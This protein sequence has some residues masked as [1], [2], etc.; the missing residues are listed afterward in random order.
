MSYILIIGAKSD[1]AKALV[2]KYAENGY[3]LYLA[4]RQVIELESFAYDLGIRTRRNIKCLELDLLDF[5]SH[6]TFYNSIKEKPLGVILAVGYLGEQKKARRDFGEARKIID[7]NFTGAVSMLNIITD[8]F[9]ERKNGF[10]VGI[11]SVAGDRG[12]RKNYIYGSAKSAFTSYLSGLRSNLIGANV[13]ILT[14]IPGY[15]Y[16]KMTK[17][18]VLPEKLTARP[19]EVAEDIYKAQQ[20]GVNILYTKGIWYWIMFIIRNIPENLFKKLNL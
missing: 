15:V 14:V 18:M 8:D 19:K 20:K 4:A 6:K 3:D 17:G 2:I 7:T 5:E 16:T 11:S 12:K 10:I 1:I 13:H 9:E